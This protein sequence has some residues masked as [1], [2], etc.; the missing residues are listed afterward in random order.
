M[1]VLLDGFLDVVNFVGSEFFLLPVNVGFDVRW[2]DDA[3]VEVML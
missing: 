3:A 1:I 2:D